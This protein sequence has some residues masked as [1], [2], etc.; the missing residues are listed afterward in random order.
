MMETLIVLISALAIAKY[1]W[2]AD[3]TDEEIDEA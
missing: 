3:A 1:I 2:L